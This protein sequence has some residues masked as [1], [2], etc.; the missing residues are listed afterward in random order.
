MLRLF[1][2]ISFFPLEI[3]V[4]GCGSLGGFYRE[5]THSWNHLDYY[6]Q[7]PSTIL[8]IWNMRG[9]VKLQLD[10]F[11]PFQTLLNYL[12]F[13]L[14]LMI[15]KSVM[16]FLSNRGIEHYNRKDVLGILQ[17]FKLQQEKKSSQILVSAMS[18]REFT[19]PSSLQALVQSIN[20]YFQENRVRFYAFWN[21]G[22]G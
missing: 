1:S 4:G 19:F 5:I 2:E 3:L 16:H 21:Q 12:C 22:H 13:I 6:I 9:H 17:K 10:N 7:K 11:L 15:D 20:S 18:Q 8:F 14:W